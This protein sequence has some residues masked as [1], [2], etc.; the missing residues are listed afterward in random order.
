MPEKIFIENATIVTMNDEDD[1]LFDGT[2]VIEG[3]TIVAIG[4]QEAAIGHNRSGATVIDASGMAA[5][6]GFVDLHY[7]TSIGKG[8]VDHL[9]L[10]EILHSFWYPMIRAL[11]P[12]EAYWAAMASYSESLKAGVTTANDM[13]RQLPA[14]ARA[15]DDSGIRVVLS[16]DIADPEHELDLIEDNEAA[17]HECH[18]MANGRV[19][20][21]VGIEWLPLASEQLLV[22]ARA[23]ADKLD[24]GVHIHLNES[25]GEID[26]SVAAFGGRRPTEV[27][28]DTGILGSDCVAAHCVHLS[29]H[30]IGLMRETGTHISHNP[31][32]NAKLGNGV[33]RLPEMLAAGL[34]IGLGHDSA[35]GTNTCD[36]F[37][38]MKWASLLHRAVRTDASLLQPPEVLRMAT[39]NGALAL[40]HATGELSV[41]KLA[42]VILIDLQNHHFTPLVKE[43]KTHLYSHLVFS[44]EGSVVD[45][46]I[47]DGQ[48][49]MQNRE[50]ITFDEK[51]VLAKATESFHTVINR[52]VIPPEYANL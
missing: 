9:P 8:Y 31:T 44:S 39:R 17:Y 29:D 49:I 22:D 52:M 11:N 42:D 6:P 7:H 16:N 50:F 38:L 23:L 20:V 21:W 25:Q 43:S 4:G 18:G 14:L 12:E 37:Q 28:Y 5:L 32:S 41:G 51:E 1:V 10:W 46:T 45:T 36:V 27:A 19:Q 15:A 13:F 34:N 3:N 35:E 24:T 33:A 2:M 47:V 30:E 48:I 26:L 40:G